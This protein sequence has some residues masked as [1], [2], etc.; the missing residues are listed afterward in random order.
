MSFSTA[1][2]GPLRAEINITPMIDVLLVLIIVFMVVVSMSKE[3][4]LDAQ[5]PQPAPNDPHQQSIDR[6]IVIQIDWSGEEKEPKVKINDESVGWANL[7]ERLFDIFKQ[8]AERVAFVK[9]DDDVDFQYVADAISIART[10][11]V[12]KIG[13][14]TKTGPE[15]P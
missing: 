4:G 6:T 9:G 5:I 8:R 1:G 2:G 14:L 12:E 7:Q 15:S 10:S 3:K 11:G 13:L